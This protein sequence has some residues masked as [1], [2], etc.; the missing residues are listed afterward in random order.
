MFTIIG[1]LII[2]ALI[3]GATKLVRF[4]LRKGHEQLACP[5]CDGRGYWWSVRD[6]E[7]CKVCNGTGKRQ[8]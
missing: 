4:L 7:F 6:K 5:N 2:A 1:L 8:R 3:W